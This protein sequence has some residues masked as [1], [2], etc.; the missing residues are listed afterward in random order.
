[1]S[2]RQVLLLYK[3]VLGKGLIVFELGHVLL[4]L[5]QPLQHLAQ[6][7]LQLI[8]AHVIAHVFIIYLSVCCFFGLSLSG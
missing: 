7:G 1:M 5:L 3:F 8:D 6:Y 4:Q 2:I